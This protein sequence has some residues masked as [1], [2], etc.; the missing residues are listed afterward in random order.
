M[1]KHVLHIPDYTPL[2]GNIVKRGV[3]VS[4]RAKKADRELF[5]YY[6][7]L[8]DIPVPL[9]RRRVSIHVVLGWGRRCLDEDNAVKVIH[10]SLV[11]CGLLRND[12]PVWLERGPVR[13][14]R[15][16]FLDH[17]ETFIIL[18]DV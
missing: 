12:S 4:H 18:E 11:Q 7:R 14:S 10:D 13:W 9:G 17:R 1:T 8:T 2:S 5:A 6:A 15:A 3:R 16:L